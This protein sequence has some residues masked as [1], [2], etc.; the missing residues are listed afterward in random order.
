MLRKKSI[1]N[2]HV[3]N[4]LGA[5]LQPHTPKLMSNFVSNFK[6]TFNNLKGKSI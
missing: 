3:V 6:V 5:P 1:F 2:K 4:P